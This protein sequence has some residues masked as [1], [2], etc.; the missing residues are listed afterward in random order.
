VHLVFVGA[1]I[2]AVVATLGV[3][4]P[5]GWVWAL[6][7]VWVVL[8]GLLNYDHHRDR[9]SILNGLKR[10]DNALVYT[11]LVDSLLGRLRR[12]LSPRDAVTDPIPENG[13]MSRLISFR[14]P[15]ARDPEDLMRLQSSTFSWPVMDAALKVAVIYPLLLLL[16]QWGLS[17]AD[18]GIVAVTILAAEDRP[19][20][21]AAVVCP[22]AALMISRSLASA[23]QM[24]VFEKAPKWLHFVGGAVEF[25][26]VGAAAASIVIFSP[27][28]S[29]VALAA[30][31]AVHFAGVF[32]AIFAA[33]FAL[34]SALA[35]VGFVAVAVAGA[36]VVG[37]GCVKGTGGRSYAF[38][39]T[40][41]WT[42]LVANFALAT[43]ALDPERRVLGFALGLLPLINAVF[44]YLSYGVT[45][46]LVRYGRRQRNLLTG[47][48]WVF[49]GAAAILLLIGL[50]LALS[51]TIA[52]INHLAGQEFIA[53]RPIFD[54][55]KTPDG[56]AGY[57]WLTL[58]LL[59]TLVP[60][61]VHLVLVFLSA[62]TWVPTRFKL[63]IARG[64][65]DDDTGDLATL[66]GSLAAATLGA[67][68][69]ALVAGGL[70]GVWLFLTA[71]VEPA[72]L[73]VLW[74]VESIARL[75]GWVAPAAT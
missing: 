9:V 32:A 59:S 39:V 41:L 27:V 23:S 63:W 53:L 70:W 62:F 57:T 66:G 26:A 20:L 11:R 24:P 60:T 29:G 43:D 71:Y 7:L 47:L 17:G 8:F 19:W 37:Y 49:D 68:W 44:D 14:T 13:W 74:A 67:L 31:C 5:A 18:T 21:R 65:G 75:L 6:S 54:D 51:G 61:L 64:I 35:G 34:A 33:S 38:L 42:V 72:G 40:M 22:I 48:V 52:L 69:A 16:I 10:R 50:G 15:R 56:R 58:T 73:T 1:I 30:V 25:A 12:I 46:G 28:A 55:L 4:Q 45:F 3:F 2:A 36:G